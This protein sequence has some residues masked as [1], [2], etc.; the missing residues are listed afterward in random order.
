MPFKCTIEATKTFQ[1]SITLI[2]KLVGEATFTITPEALTVK[3]MDTSRVAMV[4]FSW[5]KTFFAEYQAEE[6]QKICLNTNELLKLL[7]RCVT[8]DKLE[9]ELVQLTG[10]L[11]LTFHGKMTRNFLLPTLEPSEE[12]VPTPKLDYNVKASL[13]TASLTQS[14]EDAALVSD[15][16][17]ITADKEKIELQAN[18]DLMN[19]DITIQNKP[20]DEI[21]LAL[22]SKA[23]AKSCYS[24]SYLQEIIKAGSALADIVTLELSTY[25]PLKLDFQEQ[26]CQI[27]F[28]LAPRIDTE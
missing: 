15:H 27:Q 19:A 7:K 4:N 5:P 9:L 28:W 24:L 14:I 17:Y 26:Q 8:G 16:V 6:T 20:E 21:L 3:T 25:M 23:P 22:E 18:G 2:N 1:D 10:K 13:A 12:E 11:R